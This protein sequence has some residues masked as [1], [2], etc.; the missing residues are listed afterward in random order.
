MNMRY[1]LIG[2]VLAFLSL[3]SFIMVLSQGWHW[4][5]GANI[6]D[7]IRR[8]L[9]SGLG[10]AICFISG[11]IALDYLGS[12]N[13]EKNWSTET[14]GNLICVISPMIVLTIFG[15]FI[16][17]SQRDITRNILFARLNQIIHRAGKQK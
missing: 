8:A 11:V 10:F 1:L 2:L 13:S 6:L 15:S 3:S 14:L 17:Y 4:I 9:L 5:P 12:P 16:W 7:R